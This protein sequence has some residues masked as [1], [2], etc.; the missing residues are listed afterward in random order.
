M[1]TECDLTIYNSHKP[2]K[3]LFFGLQEVDCMFD[4]LGH[5]NTDI[6]RVLWR[7]MWT[8]EME[9]PEDAIKSTAGVQH[10]DHYLVGDTVYKPF[11]VASSA[12][13]VPSTR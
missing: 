13:P 1:T 3:I 10:N 4:R 12:L 5:Q 8:L 2:V 6:K 7:E 9:I 11:T